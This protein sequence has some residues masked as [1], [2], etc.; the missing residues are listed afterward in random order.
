MNYFRAVKF[1]VA[2]SVLIASGWLVPAQT[3]EPSLDVGDMLDA[4][5]QFAQDNLDPDVVKA[6]QDV[7]RTKVEDFLKNYQDYLEGDYVLDVAQLGASQPMSTAWVRARLMK[8][9][10]VL[11]FFPARNCAV[12]PEKV[13]G[14]LG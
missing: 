8:S 2:I 1:R 4:A 6:L 7:D 14:V 12:V 5:Q 11:V 9:V 10:A 3:N 13:K